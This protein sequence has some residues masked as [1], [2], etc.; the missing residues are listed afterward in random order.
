MTQESESHPGEGGGEGGGGDADVTIPIHLDGSAIEEEARSIASSL[1][2]AGTEAGA[3]LTEGL[4]TGAVKAGEAI[5]AA[6]QESLAAAR[7]LADQMARTGA[8]VESI[9]QGLSTTGLGGH[10]GDDEI[11]QL[12]AQHR[13]VGGPMGR[14]RS[15][16]SHAA[17]EQQERL[18]DDERAARSAEQSARVRAANR[19]R[20]EAEQRQAAQKE[21][22]ELTRRSTPEYIDSLGAEIRGRPRNVIPFQ[23]QDFV[24]N[25]STRPSLQ[26]AHRDQGDYE[27]EMA[28]LRAEFEAIRRAQLRATQDRVGAERLAVQR[29]PEYMRA[30][31]ANIR[32]TPP[33]QHVPPV[34]MQ[35]TVAPPPPPPPAPQ[36]ALP[37]PRP[38]T[39]PP[40]SSAQPT[41]PPA[42]GQPAPPTT[43]PSTGT[44]RLQR[45]ESVTLSPGGPLIIQRVPAVA[46]VPGAI[47][48]G[49]A[50]PATVAP[51]SAPMAGSVVPGSIAA[52]YPGSNVEARAPGDPST[53]YQFRMRAV[54][55]SSLVPSNLIGGAVNPAF[56]QELQPRDRS[57]AMSQVQISEIAK[58]LDPRWLLENTGITDRGAPITGPGGVVEGGSG[59]VLGMQTAQKQFP[60]RW[61]AYQNELRALAPHLG[62][63]PHEI[64]DDAVLVRER[65]QQLSPAQRV[66]FAA[67][68]NASATLQMSP[69]EHALHE[70]QY[71][72]SDQ[73]SNLDVGSGEPLSRALQ[74]PANRPLV[75]SFMYRVPQNEQAALRNKEGQ[76]TSEGIGRVSNALFARTYPGAAGEKALHA[77]TESKDSGMRNTLN[78]LQQSLPTMA[79]AKELVDEGHRAPELDVT[80][81]LARAVESLADIRNRGGTVDDSIKQSSMFGRPLNTFQEKLLRDSAYQLIAGTIGQRLH[82]LVNVCDDSLRIGGHQRVDIGFDE[83][84]RVELLI[85]QALIELLLLLFHLLAGGIIRAD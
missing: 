32:A 74:R 15:A 22:S 85:A 11:S 76:L 44:V 41:P 8:S 71:L 84:T 61:A 40:P 72:H 69:V 82:L 21:T 7:A 24:V 73:V 51:S 46:P 35:S 81:D 68:T 63:Q 48:G 75:D 62:I 80:E 39:T 43:A 20:V 49:G 17:R 29:T 57:R 18:S 47:S 38:P 53:S 52:S 16:A 79:R 70:R 23:K 66:A 45:G 4:R 3:A 14:D 12:T 2:Q 37:P 42:H 5:T 28:A 1:E 59:R 55:L 33:G 78:A 50:A 27:G 30:Y 67:D 60:E 10:I 83:G 6:L 26:A 64:P 13:V 58:R 56:P 77:L 34:V 36:L 31:A 25:S 65:T 54:P 19:Q 9:R